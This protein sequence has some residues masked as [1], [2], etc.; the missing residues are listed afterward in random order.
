MLNAIILACLV[1]AV[2]P[3]ISFFTSRW[4]QEGKRKRAFQRLLKEPLLQP[5]V[6]Q[7]DLYTPNHGHCICSDAVVSSL[8]VGRVEFFWKGESGYCQTS[9]TGLE[10]ESLIWIAKLKPAEK[11]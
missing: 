11:P 8:E 3:F 6:Y 7:I 2:T 10:V 5:G 1:A 4:I 9:F